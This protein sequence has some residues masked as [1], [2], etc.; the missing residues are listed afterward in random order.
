MPF[1]LD[2]QTVLR[3]FEPDSADARGDT[4]AGSCSYPPSI[5]PLYCGGCFRPSL[6]SDRSINTSTD[7][8]ADTSTD[9]DA[10]TSTIRNRSDS[11]EEGRQWG[12]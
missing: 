2:V 4:V 9:T 6:G 7:T 8:D 11:E 10:D 3:G 5:H 1:F 12:M